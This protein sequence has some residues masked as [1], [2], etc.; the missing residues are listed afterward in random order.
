MQNVTSHVETTKK[1]HMARIDKEI[2]KQ[3]YL[4]YSQ[5]ITGVTYAGEKTRMCGAASWHSF[6]I[7]LSHLPSTIILFGM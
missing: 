2:A 4:Q 5:A 1:N 3:I 7:R 6:I